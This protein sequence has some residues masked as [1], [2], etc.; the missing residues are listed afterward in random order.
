MGM[1]P[2]R[3]GEDATPDCDSERSFSANGGVDEISAWD[4]RLGGK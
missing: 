1:R 3:G 4:V 2:G